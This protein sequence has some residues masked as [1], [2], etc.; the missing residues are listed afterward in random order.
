MA[1]TGRSISP[2][3]STQ[4]AEPT[5]SAVNAAT[6]S[7]CAQGTGSR[8]ARHSST[9]AQSTP[10]VRSCFRSSRRARR[11][12]TAALRLSSGGCSSI[13]SSMG[14]RPAPGREAPRPAADRRE[15]PR[16]TA[17]VRRGSARTRSAASPRAGAV[18]R[19]RRDGVRHRCVPPHRRDGQL[20]LIDVAGRRMRIR[21][22]DLSPESPG[23]PRRARAALSTA[24]R[25]TA[26]STERTAA[27][28]PSRGR[29]H[30]ASG[31]TA[32]PPDQSQN[33]DRLRDTVQHAATAR[34]QRGRNSAAMTT[35]RKC[36]RQ[37]AVTLHRRGPR[38]S[39]VRPRAASPAGSRRTRSRRPSR[40]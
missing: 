32:S 30:A 22:H 11:Q 1:S 14:P 7:P 37:T 23:L 38:G 12:R 25:D 18:A 35:G 10:W 2:A 28:L 33:R 5:T 31:V 24:S 4:T 15:L 13:T 29:V 26:I 16:P 9:H 8:P 27:R 39:G 6:A 19:R 40:R 17:P 21:L 20:V 3:L 36:H 34:P